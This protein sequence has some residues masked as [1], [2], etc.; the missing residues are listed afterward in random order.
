M[1]EL[2]HSLS[3]YASHIL[4]DNPELGKGIDDRHKG[5]GASAAQGS[6]WQKSANAS[7]KNCSKPSFS[8]ASPQ[9]SIHQVPPSIAV[10]P[11]CCIATSCFGQGL[12]PYKAFVEM[13]DLKGNLPAQNARTCLSNMCGQMERDQD[14]HA[15]EEEYMCAPSCAYD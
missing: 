6:A 11:H 14:A 15:T 2:G 9:C 5:P 8:T 1:Q 12:V 10:P 4:E 13:P 3:A 7:D